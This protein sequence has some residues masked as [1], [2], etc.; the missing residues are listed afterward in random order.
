MSDRTQALPIDTCLEPEAMRA[1]LQAALPGFA[2]GR[3]GIEQLRISKV[4]RSSSRRRHPFPLTL[5][6]ELEVGDALT[7]TLA[8]RR[9]FGKVYRDGASAD[10]A[11]G[12]PSLHLPQLDMRLWPWPHDPGLP[13]LLQLLDPLQAAHYLPAG[14]VA[15]SGSVT[16][17]ETLRYEPERRATLRYT[18]S[19]GAAQ[20]PHVVYGKTFFDDQARVLHERFV[21][22]WRLAQRD[23]S[24]PCVAEP[25]G[26]DAATRTLW[27][28]AAGGQ[29][30][31]ALAHAPAAAD[32]FYAVGCALAH[33][34]QAPLETTV[35]RP[36]SHWLTELQRRQLKL[37]RAAPELGPRVAAIAEALAWASHDL[38]AAPPTLI[39]GDFHPDQVWI[40]AG[41]VVLFDFD[42]F[43][44]GNPMEDLAE[45]I[46]KLELAGLRAAQ[47]DAAV[48]ALIAGYR[49][50]AP[51]RFDSRSLLWHRA[52]QS[53]LQ[54]SR[55][56]IYQ[57]PGWREQ[58][59]VRLARTEQC[60]AI[61]LKELKS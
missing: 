24:A 23:A 53:L 40:D 6:Y 14:C 42:E 54:A 50:G 25:L 38:P 52:M 51:A 28:A 13:Q 37:T 48:A 33:V 15:A 8:E 9:F 31:L 12:T 61:T 57:A 29:A 41:R 49:S 26:F 59:A 56:F 34:H 1:M 21:Y 35:R 27:Q 16:A 3:L 60:L 22:F 20:A 47:H 46:V 39:H 18:L 19:G 30:L 17:V 43:A 32:A 58:L 55:A 44:I 36:L 45:F 7:G 10:A 2:D 4:R 11:P 5:C